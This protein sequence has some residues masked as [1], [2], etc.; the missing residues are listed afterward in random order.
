MEI[1]DWTGHADNMVLC[2]AAARSVLH[3]IGRGY[4][5]FLVDEITSETIIRLYQKLVE[6]TVD[7]TRPLKPFVRG[8]AQNVWNNMERSNRKFASLPDIIVEIPEAPEFSEFTVKI[9]CRMRRQL[10]NSAKMLKVLDLYERGVVEADDI[11]DALGI[12]KESAY[13]CKERIQIAA[14]DAHIAEIEERLA[15][16]GKNPSKLLLEDALFVGRTTI[17]KTATARMAADQMEELILDEL[18]RDKGKAIHLLA[19]HEMAVHRFDDNAM[20]DPVLKGLWLQSMNFDSF[21]KHVLLFK[22]A[23]TSKQIIIATDR[24]RYAINY[25]V[26]EHFLYTTQILPASDLGWCEFT[27]RL[28]CNAVEAL[29]G[30]LSVMSHGRTHEL[31]LEILDSQILVIP[32]KLHLLA[33]K[34]HRLK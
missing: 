1:D 22:D 4:E 3:A 33:K 11:A 29:A 26:H 34:F 2:R 23:D 30:S 32:S 19:F 27:E 12:S 31:L 28:C 8:I 13:K 10:Q 24:I 15:M 9:L 5:D 25:W 21:S 16:F 17:E 20:S 6:K 18:N 7:L 14:H